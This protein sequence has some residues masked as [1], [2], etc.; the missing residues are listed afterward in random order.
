MA[1]Q[2][3]GSCMGM[4]VWVH[5]RTGTGAEPYNVRAGSGV[6][7]V[8]SL[9][10]WAEKMADSGSYKQLELSQNRVLFPI[11]TQT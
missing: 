4:H 2:E 7:L 8:P 11:H 9:T 1:G 6:S 5:P 3:L 10:Q